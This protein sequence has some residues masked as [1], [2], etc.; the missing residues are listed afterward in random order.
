MNIRVLGRLLA[1]HLALVAG[2]WLRPAAATSAPQA[3]LSL[4]AATFG[5][6]SDGRYLAWLTPDATAQSVTI[7]VFDTGTQSRSII[8]RGLA[9]SLN[10]SLDGPQLSL[11]D[12]ILAY[13]AGVGAGAK[14]AAVRL[15]S[16]Q[17]YALA[18][19][20]GL[21]AP[22]AAG[23]RVYWW[24]QPA[25]PAAD[26]QLHAAEL[27]GAETVIATTARSLY[28][29]SA[30]DA[31][32]GW[33]AWARG[34]GTSHGVLIC[35]DLWAVEI[36]GGT[37]RQIG[38]LGCGGAHLSARASQL[39]YIDADGM[40]VRRDLYSGASVRSGPHCGPWGQNGFLI[41]C[42]GLSGFTADGRYAFWARAQ[43]DL[44]SPP[45]AYDIR[46]FDTATGSAFL[47]AGG[48]PEAAGSP[49][50]E[51]ATYRGTLAWLWH[52][53]GDATSLRLGAL[54]ATLP[55]APEP[56]E[57]AGGPYFPETGHS[58][59]GEF[60]AF[61]ERSGGLPAFGYPLT[62]EFIQESKDD[63]QGYTVQYLERQ[64]FE[65]HPENGGTPYAVLIGRM[66]AEAL[67]AQG[68]DWQAFPQADPSA[69]H[70][71]AQ[72]GQAIGPE[73]WQYWR[74]H[75]L[76]LGDPGLSEREALALWGYP[77]SPPQMETLESGET[78]L[79]QW[80]ERARFEYHPGN[81]APYKVLLGRLAAQQVDG[82]DWD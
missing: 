59:R 20:P 72:T 11:R 15:D 71:F 5:L 54:G 3:E 21:S 30:L 2:L 32:A 81:P 8:E 42:A 61:W 70:Y 82:F 26:A 7:E 9:S 49:G 43:G 65:Y 64:R 40:L 62:G 50:P 33:I 63:G 60:R 35:Y 73:F 27:G 68:R 53:A 57:A 58:L 74:G 56:P 34:T 55:S 69:P 75:G 47:I 18:E 19:G 66:G 41:S 29:F 37:P 78:L 31:G 79:V 76:D 12:G 25:D 13:R 16:N 45:A 52:P 38:Q 22:A 46:G 6:V 17:R 39:I 48:L 80:F 77:L 23:D 36:G 24:S 44:R 51:L 10:S 14:V 28:G 67:A 1:L 4:P